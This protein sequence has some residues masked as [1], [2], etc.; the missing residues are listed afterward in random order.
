MLRNLS[1]LL[2]LAFAGALNAQ[3]M[4]S[5]IAEQS[6]PK[7][8]ER[9]IVP[10]V[11]RTVSLDLKTLQPVLAAAPERFTQAAN[12]TDLPVLG[13]PMPDGSTQHFRMTESPVMAP[14]LQSKYPEI[15]TYTGY[16]IDDPT[17]TLKCVLT[18]HGFHAMVLSS[19]GNT[20][21]I[22]PYSVG[23]QEHY[24]V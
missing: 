15:R 5:E 13:L 11:Y 24:V 19:I 10:Q 22:D 21:F 14:E 7:T 4:W 18:P 6:I 8:G 20:V 23:D 2:L 12:K 16:G 1:V 3:V 17:A 9:Q